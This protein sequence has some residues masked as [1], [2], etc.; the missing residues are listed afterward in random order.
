MNYIQELGSR[1]LASRLKKFTELLI[2]DVIQ[3]Y[4]EQKID[5]QPRW[6]TFFLLISEIVEMSVMDIS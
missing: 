3:I 2:R 6:Y 5:F 4:K 1:A